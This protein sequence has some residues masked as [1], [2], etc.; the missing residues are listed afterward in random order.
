[1]MIPAW[2]HRPTYKTGTEPEDYRVVAHHQPY[3]YPTGSSAVTAGDSRQTE[4]ESR[5]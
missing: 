1:M 3:N 2:G 4:E 5:A